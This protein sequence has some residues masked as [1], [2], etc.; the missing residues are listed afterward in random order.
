[1]RIRFECCASP[2]HSGREDSD[3]AEQ[4]PQLRS[5]AAV[6]HAPRLLQFLSHVRPP[7]LR[8]RC[9]PLSSTR[10]IR[11]RNAHARTR[12]DEGTMQPRMCSGL[13]SDRPLG[14]QLVCS[15]SLRARAPFSGTASSAKWRASIW[16]SR[17]ALCLGSPT[18]LSIRRGPRPRDLGV[19][20]ASQK[21]EDRTGFEG[22]ASVPD[23]TDTEGSRFCS[24]SVCLS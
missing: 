4:K 2:R 21:E 23:V 15:S 7:T 9:P 24:P 17:R 3:A 20:C 14:K 22:V 19:R 12:R 1:M 10:S 5:L 18:G 16:R 11:I 6:R 13:C 8:S